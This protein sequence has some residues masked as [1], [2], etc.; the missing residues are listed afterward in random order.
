MPDPDRDHLHVFRKIEY[1]LAPDS[2]E[3]ITLRQSGETHR[4]HWC[5]LGMEAFRTANASVSS[6]AIHV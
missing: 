4:C 5:G 1:E 6:G 3:A 2:P